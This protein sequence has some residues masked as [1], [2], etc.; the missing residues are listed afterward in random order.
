[1]RRSAVLTAFSLAVLP[2]ASCT[3]DRAMGVG[4]TV[5]PRLSGDCRDQCA[6]LEMRLTAVVLQGASGACVC[7]PEP[8]TAPASPPRAALGGAAGA[9]VIATAEAKAAEQSRSHQS[10]GAPPGTPPGMASGIHR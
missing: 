5:S 4:V 7:E 2:L 10:P 8:T 1:M 6:R 9:F 3:L